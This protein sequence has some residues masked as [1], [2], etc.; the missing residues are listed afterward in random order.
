MF[1]QWMTLT[2]EKSMDAKAISMCRLQSYGGALPRRYIDRSEDF[3]NAAGI[4]AGLS[5]H[6]PRLGEYREVLFWL[7]LIGSWQFLASRGAKSAVVGASGALMFL[8]F[9][10]RNL[11]RLTRLGL[12]YASWRPTSRGRWVLAAASGLIAGIVIFGIG[13]ASGQGMIM[14]SNWRL[15]LLQV[16][17]G[18]VLEE[19]VFRGYLFSL[20]I[21]TLH[22]AASEAVLNWLVVVT[23]AVAFALVHLAQPGVSWLQLACI[24]IT[25]SLYGEG[26]GR[27][28]PRRHRP[29]LRTHS[30]TSRCMGPP[31]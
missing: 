26:S 8:V 29:P 22:R 31:V 16:T 4:V 20:L 9:A 12:E 30:T 7:L 14:S 18:P 17:L 1:L 21:W 19:V 24:T 28:R 3:C 23:G 11:G 10:F 5:Q 6:M 15:V 13:S 2:N 25:R 27:C